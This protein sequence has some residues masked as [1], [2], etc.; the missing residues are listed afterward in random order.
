MKKT[1]LFKVLSAII[2]LVVAVVT[3]TVTMFN[4]EE[5]HL[6][7]VQQEAL[8]HLAEEKGNYSENKIVLQNTNKARAQELALSIGAEL[9]TSKNGEFAT[10][11][12]P[13]GVS[14]EDVY[15][16]DDNRK[17][18]EE[19][20]LDYKVYLAEETSTEEEDSTLEESEEEILHGPNYQVEDTYYNMQTYLNYL[21]MQD[22]WNQ[23][24]GAYSDG[25][26][27]KVAVIDTGIDTDHPEFFDAEGNSI[28]STKSYDATNDRV[29]DM[30]DMS[31]IEDTDGHGTAVAG[32]IAA[33]F[34]GEGI[35]GIAPNVELLV[36]KCE[37]DT[38]TGSFKY[39]SDLI[40][41]I[42]YAIEQDVD[43]INMSFGGEGNTTGSAIK[44]A[45]DSD[46]I[47]VAAAGNES[48]D[49]LHYPAADPNT[50]G[51]GALD[52]DSWELAEYSNYGLNSDI[53]APGTAFTSTVGG[54]YEYNQGTSLAA[55]I[56]SAV[57]ALYISQN[58]YVTFE[59]VKAEI[60]ASG[61][62]LGELGNDD[63]YSYGCIDVN[64][65]IF[66]EKGTITWDYCTEELE[67]EEQ[68]FVR[69]HTIQNVPDP[70]R[71]KVIFDDWYYDK[72]YT[73]VFNYDEYFTTEFV[74]D[75]TLYAKWSNEDDED[76]TAFAYTVLEDGTVEIV[77]YKGKRRHLIIPDTLDGYVVSSIGASAFSGNSK[78]KSVTM[79]S[80][81]KYIKEYAFYQCISLREV[82][83]TGNEL[84]E[85][86]RRAFDNCTSLRDIEIL[87]S[88]TIIGERAFSR[89]ST[90]KQI[91]IN[92]ISNL[93]SIGDFAFQ[94]T[95]ITSFYI[96]Q[97]ANFDG[98]IVA[99]CENIRSVTIH[100][101]NTNYVIED[102]T[103][104]NLD[105][106]SIV[107]YPSAL[108][109]DYV[110]IDSVLSIEQYAFNC[111][112]ITSC[113]MNGNVLEIKSNAF[114]NAASSYQPTTTS[115]LSI[116]ISGSAITL[117]SSASIV[118]LIVKSLPNTVTE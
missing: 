103:V 18:I 40:Y 14:I 38:Y 53:I 61:K 84:L 117:L 62:D 52:K 13:K 102:N 26:K 118:E 17:F 112:N 104:Y 23:T 4:T 97:K 94:N 25:E 49:E 44:L 86:Q 29:V 2:I 39:S 116:S 68:V 16:N 20:S 96:P 66:E 30:Y 10:L 36:I 48:T 105:K 19:M 57:M 98:T 15:K 43:V 78:L 34:N 95:K 55:P 80:R 76:S 109:G 69:Q 37:I 115:L 87:D 35:V 108:S 81:L 32:V 60:I 1:K 77:S 88:V 47:C 107:Y 63:Y 64:A 33:Q 51:V 73:R 114:S 54:G 11:T 72:A 27:V 67:N 70:E 92:E 71:D 7:S 24:Q 65:F 8:K 22:V 9:R 100:P 3:L 83:F 90:L 111:S 46:I 58:K 12:L 56:V 101:N 45:V 59:Q 99:G 91:Y 79:P 21:N 89:C 31:V 110:V 74:D 113:Y 50:I 41:G 106:T 5:N 85:I 82:E 75:I 42:Y 6:I 28:I 93:E